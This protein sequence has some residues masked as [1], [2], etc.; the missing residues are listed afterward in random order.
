MVMTLH[1][2]GVKDV[3][4][5]SSTVF[6][7]DA[8]IPEYMKDYI[9]AAYDLGYIKGINT[10]DGLCFEANRSITRAEAAVMLGNI[11]DVATPTILPTFSDSADIPVWAA[12][13]V[14]SLNSI[15]VM[16]ASGGS[17]GATATLTRGDAA[18][19]LT[20]LMNYID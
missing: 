14:Y 6:A 7:D 13:S 12:P 10:A 8:Q 11:L 17:I 20:N 15:G 4:D 2:L 3:R 19:I 5:V 9:A 16:N 18:E 1:A